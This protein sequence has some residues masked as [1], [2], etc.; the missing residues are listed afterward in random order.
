MSVVKLLGWLFCFRP[1]IWFGGSGLE[2]GSLTSVKIIVF[3]GG[4]GHIL[5][6]SATGK[7][8][9]ITIIGRR[10]KLLI[11]TV[12]PTETFDISK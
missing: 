2:M 7:V 4:R 12:S 9:V 3:Q 8:K 10:S 1:R 6:G 11:R 5:R